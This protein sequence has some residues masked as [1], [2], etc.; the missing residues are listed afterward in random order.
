MSGDELAEHGTNQHTSDGDRNTKSSGS[1]TAA[2]AEMSW[3]INHCLM[4]RGQVG[5]IKLL[6]LPTV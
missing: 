6:V 3:Q 5:G 2:Y 4:D 1:D